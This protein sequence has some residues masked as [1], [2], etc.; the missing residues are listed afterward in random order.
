MLSLLFSHVALC[1]FACPALRLEPA[2]RPIPRAVVLEAIVTQ[3]A[4]LAHA[5][6]LR[7]LVCSGVDVDWDRE[8]LGQL[9]TRLGRVRVDVGDNA[10]V[11]VFQG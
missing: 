8:G 7:E 3:L 9:L 5:P 11:F 2:Y 4:P 10:L 1:S 6:C